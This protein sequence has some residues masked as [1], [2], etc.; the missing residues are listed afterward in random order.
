M[1]GGGR[2]NHSK[3]QP[4]GRWLQRRK[5]W[6]SGITF[7]EI[8]EHNK[9]PI[10]IEDNELTTNNDK[11][12]EDLEIHHNIG[13]RESIARNLDMPEPTI[14]STPSRNINNTTCATTSM[15]I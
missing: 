5:I 4:I 10:I 7:E 14:S 9:T 8:Q 13:L 2:N 12:D 6:M 1:R 11:E 3:L 15:K